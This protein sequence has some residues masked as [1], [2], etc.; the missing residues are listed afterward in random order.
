M[1]AVGGP[2]EKIDL[3]GVLN[4]EDWLAGG[5]LEL[6]PMSSSGAELV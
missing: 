4:T 2:E 5:G 1:E 6:W 3:L